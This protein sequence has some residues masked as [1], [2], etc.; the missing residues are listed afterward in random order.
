MTMR[1]S[2]ILIKVRAMAM[3]YRHLALF[4]SILAWVLGPISGPSLAAAEQDQGIGLTA[5]EQA[6]L[7]AHPVIRVS[8][9]MDWAPYD[10]VEDGEAKGFS[11]DYLRL[12]AR[13]TGLN[14][15]FVHGLTWAQILEHGKA[16]KLDILHTMANTAER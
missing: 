9:E 2:T 13:K 7:D 14:L 6:W 3:P 16:Q 1:V 11:I 5:Q 4:L 15:E 8:N 12:I 10:F